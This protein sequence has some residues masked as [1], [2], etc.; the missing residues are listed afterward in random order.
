MSSVFDNISDAEKVF[1]ELCHQLMM[2]AS[3][4]GHKVPI[5]AITIDLEKYNKEHS[6]SCSFNVIPHL[7]ND[8]H[9][10]N[11]LF[12]LVDYIR[13]KYDCNKFVEV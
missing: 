6:G 5:L 1:D 4:N 13:E 8:E 7:E 11:T 10:K 12:E 9:I 2:E 3:D